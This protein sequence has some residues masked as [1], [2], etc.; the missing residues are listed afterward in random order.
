MRM[1]IVSAVSFG[2]ALADIFRHNNV[3]CRD[4]VRALRQ[5]DPEPSHHST[6][7]ERPDARSA[8]R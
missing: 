5:N 1:V 6:I 2:A 8:V 4:S 3:W 7:R